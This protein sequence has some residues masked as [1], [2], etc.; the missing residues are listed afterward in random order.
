MNKNHTRLSSYE[1]EILGTALCLDMEIGEPTPPLVPVVDAIMPVPTQGRRTDYL[2]TSFRT[3]LISPVPVS[4]LHL[5]GLSD[6]SRI[7]LFCIF[8]HFLAGFYFFITSVLDLH[9]VD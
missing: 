5:F 3:S 9:S 4:T 1:N 8:S 2:T 7:F 6:T